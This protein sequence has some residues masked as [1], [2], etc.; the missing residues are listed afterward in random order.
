MR[1]IGFFKRYRW[2]A[3]CYKSMNAVDI[4]QNYQRSKNV[5]DILDG[6]LA[7]PSR[8]SPNE[9]ALVAFVKFCVDERRVPHQEHYD[10]FDRWIEE[11]KISLENR[12]FD[13]LV[14]ILAMMKSLEPM[15]PTHPI[16]HQAAFESLCQSVENKL[17][18]A[19]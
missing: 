16:M 4:P 13:Y 19:N 15:S 3:D 14:E 9:V 8:P 5:S 17:R 10:V 18:P 11:G 7:A 2:E 12:F 6:G 1:K